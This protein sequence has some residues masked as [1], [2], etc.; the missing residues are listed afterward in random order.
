MK[1]RSIRM[2]SARVLL[3]PIS[4]GNGGARWG[5]NRHNVKM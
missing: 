2:M 5:L 3:G 4:F 1:P